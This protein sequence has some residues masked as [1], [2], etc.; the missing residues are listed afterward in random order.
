MIYNAWKNETDPTKKAKLAKMLT[1]NINT[2]QTDLYN[3]PEYTK[4]GETTG[5][6][7]KKIG[8]LS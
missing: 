6:I 4:Y 8:G 7:A 1:E 5:E 2:A 3:L